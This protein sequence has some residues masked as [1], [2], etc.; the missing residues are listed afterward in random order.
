MG[1]DKGTLFVKNIFIFKYGE[2]RPTYSCVDCF[3]CSFWAS[4]GGN[5][6]TRRQIV[7]GKCR[8][9]KHDI[10]HCDWCLELFL[11]AL[12]PH[13]CTMKKF[14]YQ[15]SL[16]PRW[17]TQPHDAYQPQDKH[18]ETVILNKSFLFEVFFHVFCYRSEKLISTTAAMYHVE[19]PCISETEIISDLWSLVIHSSLNILSTFLPFV[20]ISLYD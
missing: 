8:S 19:P 11:L 6:N 18:F 3:A 4:F 2:V 16:F 10:K 20:V 12:P 1:I 14:L 17:S 13:C 15:V 5:G 9:I 7:T